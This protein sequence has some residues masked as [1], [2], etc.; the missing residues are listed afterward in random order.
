MTMTS[1]FENTDTALWA[2]N[3]L[4]FPRLLAEIAATQELDI[5]ALS[6]AM[7]LEE[8]AIDELLERA[9]TAWAKD[10]AELK[11]KAT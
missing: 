9:Q 5:A 3:D 10:K 7:D 1:R 8:D 4:Q 11:G 6:E 2:R